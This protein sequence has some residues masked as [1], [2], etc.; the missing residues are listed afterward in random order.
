MVFPRAKVAVFVDGC[1]W[2]GCTE[3]YIASK[4]NSTYWEEKV[5][6][7]RVRDED[8]NRRL[9]EAGWLVIR[10]WEHED[11]QLTAERIVATVRGRLAQ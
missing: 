1:F 5:S 6:R 7:N 8:T 9:E 3:H 4:S 2:H 10:A 11:P